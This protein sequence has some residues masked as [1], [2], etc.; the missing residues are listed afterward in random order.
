MFCYTG[1]LLS[2]GHGGLRG[3]KNGESFDL[4]YF[5]F[6][7]SDAI[8]TPG[9]TDTGIFEDMLSSYYFWWERQFIGH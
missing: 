6:G 8:G 9:S 7:V 4:W 2:G 1:S 3:L 5:G